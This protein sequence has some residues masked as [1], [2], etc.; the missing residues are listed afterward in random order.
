MKRIEQ[1]WVRHPVVATIARIGGLGLHT[2]VVVLVII[3][4]LEL[5]D[6]RNQR[7]WWVTLAVGQVAAI[8]WA[9]SWAI[10]IVVEVANWFVRRATK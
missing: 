1:D 5:V 9:G 7:V 8:A 10:I 6:A 3:S 4:L 2:A